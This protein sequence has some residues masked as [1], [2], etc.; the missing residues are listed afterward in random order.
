MSFNDEVIKLSTQANIVLKIGSDYFAQYEVD[1]GLSVDADKLGLIIAAKINSV[2]VD[3]RNV[4]TPIG[5][6]D[7]SLLDKDGSISEYIMQTEGNLLEERVELYYGFITGSYDFAD[8]KKL[9]D[10]KIKSIKKVANAYSF[11][12]QE[13]TTLINQNIFQTNSQLDADIS[14]VATTLDLEDASEFPTSG[15]IK[16]D[17]EFMQYNGKA[18]NTLQNLSRA[19]LNSTAD[20]HGAGAD[21]FLVQEVEDNP[22]DLML[23]ILT[24]IDGDTTNGA[25]DLIAQGALGIDDALV[26]V[27][28][29][30]SVRDTYFIDDEYRFYLYD[31][32]N[33][34]K[35]LENELLNATNTRFMTVDGKI[36]L[37]VLD[38]VDLTA[39]VPEL[40]ENSTLRNAKYQLNS[41][42]V[43]N[44]LTVKYD[45]NEGLKQYVRTQI[46]TDSDSIAKFGLKQLSLNFKGI[47]ADLTGSAIA[48]NRATR[49]LSRLSTP[50]GDIQVKSKFDN[51]DLNIGSKVLLTQRYLPQQGAGLG[52]SEQLEIIGRGFD[53]IDKLVDFNLEFTSFA[54]LR[55]GLIAPSPLPTSVISQT[56]FEVPD[57]KCYRVSDVIYIE[58]ASGDMKS[59]TGVDN[60]TNRITIGSPFSTT[61][62]TSTR[63]KIADYDNASEFQKARYAFI[64]PNSGFFAD[65]LKAY[66]I[67]F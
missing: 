59:I 47:R 50:R 62:T 39:D 61:V 5:N 24:S 36:S 41:Q 22:I 58:G 48:T 33:G 53:F 23:Q 34:L 2:K 52:M 16:I 35:F 21:V 66:Q 7:F 56:E 8:Y 12:G 57:A 44:H 65:G 29:F 40:N 19:D 42:K 3:I 45:Y 26:D 60:T 15:R 64:S 6:L 17:D 13:N 37:A 43:V 31:I 25:Y 46:F 11:A 9:A 32:G 4:R 18:T 20:T 14:D 38:Q 1:S 30:E 63:I 55:I 49:L 27:A 10:V 67:V 54:G 51:A 28:G